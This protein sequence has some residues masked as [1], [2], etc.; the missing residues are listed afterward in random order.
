MGVSEHF[1][2][3]PILQCLGKLAATKIG[4]TICSEALSPQ[5]WWCWLLFLLI[6][7]LQTMNIGDMLVCFFLWLFVEMVGCIV[8]PTRNFLL[9]FLSHSRFKSNR[10][11][12]S[13]ANMARY[14]RNSL[15]LE[16]VRAHDSVWPTFNLN[17][18]KTSYCLGLYH[19]WHIFES[20]N[21]VSRHLC[22]S[23]VCKT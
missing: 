2:I 4:Q 19:P 21:L 15:G 12:F 17:I 3:E 20:I 18:Y 5:L 9:K 6:K 10:V 14:W 11:P 8:P 16:C 22:F 23:D 13:R 7:Y 1:H